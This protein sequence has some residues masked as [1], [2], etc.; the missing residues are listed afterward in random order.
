MKII[1]VFLILHQNNGYIMRFSTI[2]LLIIGLAGFL[3]PLSAQ[4]VQLQNAEI[5]QNSVLNQMFYDF[6]LVRI[7]YDE[8]TPSLS[9]RSNQ[10]LIQLVHSDFTWNLELYENEIHSGDYVLTVGTDEGIKRYHRKPA[11]KSMIGYLKTQR[12]GHAYMV[13]ADQFIAGM[14]EEGG[15]S[16]FIEPANSLDPNLPADLLVIYDREKIYRNHQVECGYE[17]Y[18]QAKEELKNPPVENT[19]EE[20]GLCLQVEIAIANDFTVFQKRGSVANVENWNTTILTLLQANYDNEFE[21]SL[22]FVQSASFVATSTGSDPWNGVNNIDQHLNVHVSWGNGGGYGAVYD[23]A[24]AWTTKYKSGAVGLAW[25][26]VICANLRYNVCSDYGGGNNCIKQLQAHELG[27]NFSAGHDASGSATIMAPSVN[28]SDTWSS[29][30]VN[31]INNHVRTRSCLSVCAGGSAPVANFIADPTSGCAQLVVH[32]TDLSTNDP[33]AWQWTFPGGTPSSSNQQ[34]PVVTYKAYGTY[35]VILK[36]TNAF[37]NNTATFKKYIFVNTVPVANFSKVVLD[38]TV[39]FTNTSLYGGTYEWDFGDGEISNEPNPTHVYD[40]DGEYIVVLTA[41]NECGTHQTSMKVTIVTIPVA[42]FTADTTYGCASY[43]VKYKNL[44]ST[45]VTS[46]EWDFPG[47]LPSTSNVFEPVVKYHIAGEFDVKLIAK[48]SKYKST[49]LKTKYIKVDSIPTAGFDHSI[50][51]DTVKFTS[52]A[53]YA[54]KYQWNFGDGSPE[55]TTN[56]PLHVYKPGT[57]T[58]VLVVKNNCGNDTFSQSITIGSGLSAGFKTDQQFGCVPFKVKFSNTSAAATSFKWSFP[59]GQPSSSVEKEPEVTYLNPGTFDV[60]LVAGNGNE[61]RTETKKSYIQVQATPEAGFIKA[62]TGFTA[63]FT[64]QS[65]FAK[66]YLWNFGDS[67]ESAEASPNHTY[68]AEGEYNVTLIT[69]N[70]CGADTFFEKVAIYLIPRVDFTVDTT[71]ICGAGSVQFIS[72]TSSDVNQWNWQFDGGNPNT[73]DVKNP[74]VHYDK[75]GLYAV[76]LAVNNSNGS[77]E[78]T[79]VSFIKVISPVLCPDFVFEKTDALN[80]SYDLPFRG[81]VEQK[82]EAIPNPFADFINLE[83]ISESAE[84]EVRIVDLY[85]KVIWTASLN[86]RGR[87]LWMVQTSEWKNGTYIVH[88]LTATGMQSKT[89]VL[90]H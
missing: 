11:N 13:I 41:E 12:G 53:K 55:D 2:L 81:K 73:S 78:I 7:Q 9:S 27:H 21:H 24:T 50:Q 60:E 52:T 39:L 17:K 26:G 71:I 15:T 83:C 18:I 38:K 16:Y 37:G 19:I 14:V 59:G 54:K 29:A 6:K 23:V 85:G 76:K 89:I 80:P 36:A 40:M 64:D 28:C 45:N 4:Q 75:K 32:F 63:L 25:V 22:E 84:G 31:S 56:H 57:Y 77:N 44:S 82:F 87:N 5:P 90:I 8:L 67:N 47:G 68:I 1:I 58:A 3:N 10:H 33:T 69:T 61:E 70:E 43:T 42:L 65:K 49:S 72:K 88:W 46:W 51:M 86:E 35:D 20:R 30:S 79:K 74:V 48:N 62:I 66:T 34:N